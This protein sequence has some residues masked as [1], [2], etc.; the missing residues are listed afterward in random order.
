M[1][2]IFRLLTANDFL[3]ALPF[4][5]LKANVTSPYAPSPIC[6]V[7]MYFLDSLPGYSVLFK[8]SKNLKPFAV[9]L[10]ANVILSVFLWTDFLFFSYFSAIDVCSI[11]R[12]ILQIDFF[13][14]SQLVMVQT[15]MGLR[16]GYQFLI[17]IVPL[18]FLPPNITSLIQPCYWN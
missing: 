7:M 16:Y 18:Q 2:F 4:S 5:C 14:R 10:V 3:L 8:L 12:K 13:G 1:F 9:S 15:E 11:K 6:L 17:N